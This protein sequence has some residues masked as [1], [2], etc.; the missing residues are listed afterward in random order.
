MR[1]LILGVTAFIFLVSACG[2]PV[3]TGSR[4]SRG[5]SDAGVADT[6]VQ[7]ADD[8]GQT[9]R[10]TGSNPVADAGQPRPDTGPPPPANGCVERGTGNRTGSKLAN[11]RLQNCNG[12]WIELHSQCGRA[13]AQ[14]VMLVTQWCPACGQAMRDMRASEDQYGP[15]L[16][17]IYVLGELGQNVPATLQA[18]AA[19]ARAKG[20]HPDEMLVDPSFATTLSGGW[21]RPCTDENG[22]FGLPQTNILDGRDMTLRWESM[23]DGRIGGVDPNPILNELMAN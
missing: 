23:C 15:D 16:D 6:G 17:A 22:S 13:K 9:A 18:C 10:D 7:A 1:F 19:V 8:A 11:L 20:V 14:L 5:N 2:P 12:D 3:S 4:G 21:V